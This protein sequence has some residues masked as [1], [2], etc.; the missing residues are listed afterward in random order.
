MTRL[1]TRLLVAVGLAMIFAASAQASFLTS[2]TMS[3]ATVIDFSTQPTVSDVP[4]PIQ[5]GTPVALN[6]VATGNPNSGLYTNYNGWGLL[7]NGTWGG[8]MTYISVNDARPGSLIFQFLSGPVSGVG[9][10]MNHV[11]NYGTALIISAYDSSHTL[12]EQ[13]NV[14]TLAAIVTPGGYNAGAFRGIGRSSADISFFEIY[15]YVPVFDDLTFTSAPV[16]IPSALLLFGPGL[17]GLAVIRTRFRWG[18]I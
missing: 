16:P 14:T 6:I 17:A 9:G 18:W 15:G 12:L 4:G 3:G 7:S 10:F 5:V 2:N 1:A 13:Y 11:P 8:G